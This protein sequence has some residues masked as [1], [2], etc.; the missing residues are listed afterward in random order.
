[1]NLTEELTALG[2]NTDEAV[3]RFMNNTALYEK[4]LKKLPAAISETPVMPLVESGDLETAASNA[5]T[6]KGVTGNLSVTPLYD[7]YTEIVQL[8]RNGEG[9]KARALLQN[10]LPVQEKIVNCINSF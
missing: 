9:E 6:L 8:L 3:K 5:H 10:I 2:C 4:M 7:A 1:M